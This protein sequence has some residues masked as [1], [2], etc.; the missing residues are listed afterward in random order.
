MRELPPGQW[1]P[2]APLAGEPAFLDAVLRAVLPSE[3]RAAAIAVATP[4]AT[5]AVGLA[6]AVTLE[7]GD[8]L[9]TRSL[10]FSA[11]ADVAEEQGRRVATFA[12]L[13]GAGR[14]D[15]AALARSLEGLAARQ[16]RVLLVLNDPCQNPTGYT[17]TSSEW[18]A[19]VDVV[20]ALARRTPV[21]VLLDAV[22]ADFA[23]AGWAPPHA[24]LARLAE[25]AD[26]LVAWSASKSLTAYGLRVG[27]LLALCPTAPR[28]RAIA[29]ALARASGGRWGNANRGG[30]LVVGSLLTE[31]SLA[32]SASRE[33]R[34]LRALLTERARTFRRS[35]ARRGLPSLCHDGGF[36]ATVSVRR[37][38]HVADA[39]RARGGFVVRQ[40]RALRIALCALPAR[41]IPT[42]VDMAADCVG[43]RE[44]SGEEGVMNAPRSYAEALIDALHALGYGTAF[45]IPGGGIASI[46]A[47]LGRRLRVVLSQ[48]EGGAAYMAMGHSLATAGREVGLCFGT[49]GPGITNLITG[50]AAAWEEK[51]PL[52]V[53]TGNVSTEL[54][55]KGAAQDAYPDGLDAIGML[56]PVTER[57]VTAMTADQ[58]I[59]LAVEL[60]DL[61][62]RTS[63]PVHLNVPVNLASLRFA[64][65]QTVGDA[66]A[67]ARAGYSRAVDARFF[68]RFGH[69]RDDAR[70]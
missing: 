10:H 52:F 6:I 38:A 20:A 37:P 67:T 69:R 18:D 51:V 56:K 47:A 41:E 33:R 40:G 22:Y 59:P 65:G 24:A 55:G 32:A 64:G 66:L 50:V 49:S 57:S 70:D 2:Y 21:T 43:E 36:F 25:S 19:V 7:R 44:D 30:M 26:V 1:A 28:R 46:F 54:V 14:F 68:D 31:V 58:I 29:A 42:L 5:G 13:D 39:M 4:G 23:P 45:G 48:H 12:M 9:L 17:M 15:V 16:K 3:L 63:R 60:H 61:A 11:Y 53:L 34:I 27:A 8:A 62:V 35:A